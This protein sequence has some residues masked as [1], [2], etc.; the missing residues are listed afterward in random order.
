MVKGT[1]NPDD[2]NLVSGTYVVKERTHSHILSSLLR[3]CSVAPTIVH[4][5]TYGHTR[6]HTHMHTRMCTLPKRYFKSNVGI[7]CNPISLQNKAESGC[8]ILIDLAWI[9]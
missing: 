6:T 7:E 1:C 9:W 8:C 5:H 3:M 4:V 2:L